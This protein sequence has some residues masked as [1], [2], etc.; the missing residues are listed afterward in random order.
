MVYIMKTSA[1]ILLGVNK[2][3]KLPVHPFNLQNEGKMTYAQ[4]EYE[5]GADTIKF[6][7]DFISKEDMF[8]DKTVLDIGCGAAGKS[9]YY[10][11][12][13]AKKVYGV[14]VVEKYREA[15]A[16]LAAEKGLSDKFEFYCGNAAKLGFED[17]FF[18]TIIMNDSMEHV[19][20]PEA[21]VRECKRV[22][23][24]G[25]RLYINFCPYYHPYGAHLSDA[26]GIPWVHAFF[27]EEAMIEAYSDAIKDC[28]DADSRLEFR[29][30][31]DENGKLHNS[32]INGMTIKRFNK[33]IKNC[34]MKSIYY[35]EV[36]LRNVF[37]FLAKIPKIKE[38]FVKMTVEILEK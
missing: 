13:G 35:R 4:W 15:S 21:V 1:K 32:Y 22:L 36:P 23:K 7:A 18:D 8:K 2:F 6:Y 3:F 17:E 11:N 12:L 20:E 9:L 33:I 14:D 30:S 29:F 25:G 19:S 10:A 5:K 26:I 37:K 24:K 27:S 34:G 31:A 38:P 16:V 28:V